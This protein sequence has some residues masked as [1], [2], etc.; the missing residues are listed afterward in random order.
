MSTEIKDYTILELTVET[1]VRG[2]AVDVEHFTKTIDVVPKEL[3]LNLTEGVE[4][5]IR[6]KNSCR[7]EGD[8]FHLPCE[9]V[10]F[11]QSNY[12]ISDEEIIGWCNRK[13]RTDNYVAIGG[14][15]AEYLYIEDNEF[16]HW[17]TLKESDDLAGKSRIYKWIF[18]KPN[19]HYKKMFADAK[20][21]H[22]E[23]IDLYKDT[24]FGEAVVAEE[25]EKVLKE[26]NDFKE[27]LASYGWIS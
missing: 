16:E 7:I 1:A 19:E 8:E 20:R 17:K 9:T 24:Y 5:G 25:K 11:S 6:F 3:K 14:R 21:K 26:S 13:Y 18:K 2:E 4:L 15:V 12:S 22:T 10:R 23:N 27:L